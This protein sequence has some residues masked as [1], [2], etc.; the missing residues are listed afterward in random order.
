M[1]D[2]FDDYAY[3]LEKYEKSDSICSKLKTYSEY[4]NCEKL[5]KEN[6]CK[7]GRN[8]LRSAYSH[9]PSKLCMQMK[10]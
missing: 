2:L 10:N 5:I 8:I 6:I 4:K 3:S 1:Q 9:F 7:S